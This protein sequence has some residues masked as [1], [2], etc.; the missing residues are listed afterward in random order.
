V[1]LLDQLLRTGSPKPI[2]TAYATPFHPDDPRSFGTQ[3]MQMNFDRFTPEGII[4]FRPAAIARTQT[5]A[6]PVRARFLSA[7]FL[8]TLGMFVRDVP[9]DPALYFIGEEI[10]LTLRAFTAGYDLFH[11]GEVIV[12]HEY[13][14]DYRPHKH[15]TDHSPENHVEIAWYERHRVSLD[16]VRQFLREPWIGE[17]GLG[18]ER[19]LAEYEAY[20]G[21]SFRHRKVQD[22]TRLSH[23]PPNPAAP[24]D[25][26]SRTVS[27]E[28]EVTIDRESLSPGVGD[29]D[30]W[31]VGFHDDQGLEIFRADA[32]ADELAQIL[33]ASAGEALAIR[34]TFE[35]EHEPVS[36]TVWPHSRSH[37]WVPKLE[38]RR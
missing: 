23:E 30:F 29:Y 26:A 4:L 9:Y 7:H 1:K 13:T 35:S 31:Y 37:H 24:P 17:Y 38:G 10:T 15:W 11:P 20:A 27:Y 28:I 22:Y 14:R 16:R 33:D 18:R 6:E 19:T 12:W 21:V 5:S 32:G 2:L 8:L 34:R 36:W 25:W 3:A